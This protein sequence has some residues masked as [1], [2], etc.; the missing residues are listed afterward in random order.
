MERFEIPLTDVTLGEEEAAAAA[1]VIRS[2]WVTMGEEVKTFEQEFA[3]MLDVSHAIAVANG[4]AALHLAFQ[5]AGLRPGDEFLVPGLT[6]VATMNA[7]LYLGGRPVPVDCTSKDDLT[8]SPSDMAHKITERTRL[9]VVMAYGGFCPDMEAILEIAQ[10]REIPVIEDA[11]HAPLAHMAIDGRQRFM[12]TI[13][14]AG[15]FSFFG[16][17]NLTTG[18]GGMI[19]TDDDSLAARLRILRSHGMTSMTWDRHRGHAVGYDVTALGYNYRLDEIRAAV[20]REQIKKLGAASE[21]RQKIAGLLRERLESLAIEGLRIPF[22]QP[23]GS[24]VHHIF[25]VLLPKTTDRD[26]FREAMKAKG[27]QT[28]VHY[29]PLNRLAIGREIWA[30]TELD[31][32]VIESIEDR[33]VTLPMSPSLTEGQVDYLCASIKEYFG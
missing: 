18:E 13:G 14:E 31:L 26:H 3:Q 28:S 8:I 11:C 30:H 32:P 15:T 16:N 33:L 21:R 22:S 27:I 2:G 23:R 1:R 29:P 10:R 24:A 7:G 20:G 25:S 19:V 12:G 5:G 4:T 6:F 17:K 9:I